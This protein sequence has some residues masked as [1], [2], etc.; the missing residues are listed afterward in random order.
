MK[1]V[2]SPQKNMHK[3]QESFSAP[4]TPK[5]G[6]WYDGVQR[7]LSE[8]AEN[9]ISVGEGMDTLKEKYG[10]RIETANSLCREAEEYGKEMEARL[11]RLQRF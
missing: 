7:T 4:K 11:D 3:L 10:L 9:R 8:V 1:N 6:I 2:D 5:F